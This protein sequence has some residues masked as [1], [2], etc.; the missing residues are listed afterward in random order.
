MAT[1]ENWFPSARKE[2]QAM[3][4]RTAEFMNK[5]GNR[6]RIGFESL[7]ANGIWYDTVFTPRLTNYFTLWNIWADPATSTILTRDNLKDAEQ[8]LFPLY[9][10]FHATLKGSLLVSNA[11]LEAMGFP[12]RGSGKRSPHPVDRLFINLSVIPIGN[13]TLHIAFENRD[14][15]SSIKPYYLTGAVIYYALSPTPIFHANELTSSRLATR[16]P[17]LLTFAP[18]QRG[19]TL[20]L[21]ARW[22]N[23]RGELGPWSETVSAIIP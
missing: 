17:C 8:T 21:A 19:Q 15:G 2:R 1:G 7:S 22:Q 4:R 16:S 9:R 14:T 3:I 5:P 11:D 6:D 18:E 13:L 20:Y 23:R 12:P 10:R